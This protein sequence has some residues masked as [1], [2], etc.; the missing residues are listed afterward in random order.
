MMYSQGDEYPGQGKFM[1][2]VFSFSG[3]NPDK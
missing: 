2:F 1:I 3:W